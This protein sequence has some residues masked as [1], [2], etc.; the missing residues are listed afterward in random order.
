MWNLARND[1]MRLRVEYLDE[2]AVQGLMK[3]LFADGKVPDLPETFAPLYCV[4]EAQRKVVLEQLPL[5]DE[6]GPRPRGTVGKRG[7]PL[8]PGSVA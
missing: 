5:F 3:V 7:N 1:P 8:F 4:K 2:A 6:W